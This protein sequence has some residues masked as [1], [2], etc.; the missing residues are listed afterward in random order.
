M[1]AGLGCSLQEFG[2]GVPLSLMLVMRLLIAMIDAELRAVASCGTWLFF[3]APLELTDVMLRPAPR[4]PPP[5][6]IQDE[7]GDPAA[8]GQK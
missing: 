4:V 2:E 6:L 7:Q 8:A 3:H 1:A 5:M